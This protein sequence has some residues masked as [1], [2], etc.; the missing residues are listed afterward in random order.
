MIPVSKIGWSSYSKFE[1]PFF[2]GTIKV[3][4]VGPDATFAQKVL[5]LTAAAEGGSWNAVNMYDSG[6]VSLGAIQF[7]DA[8]SFNVCNML[9]YIAEKCG[10]EP[11]VSKLKPALDLCKATFAKTQNGS[12]RFHVD[13]R[14][15]S[16]LD[17]QKRLY[18]G[19]SDGNLKGTFDANKKIIAKTWAAC[20]ASV[21]EIDGAVQAQLEFTMPR[22]INGFVWGKLKEDLYG[23]DAPNDGY[24]GM[25]RGMLLS[26]A[27]N[28]PALVVKRYNDARANPYTIY[29]DAWCLHILR[30]VV[31]GS[32]IKV[33]P[34]RWSTKRDLVKSMW[35]IQLPTWSEISSEMWKPTAESSV[36]TTHV[37][38]TLPAKQDAI[39]LQEPVVEQILVAQNDNMPI[40]HRTV[41]DETKRSLE[42]KRDK[43]NF[44]VRQ[45]S[46][47][48][49][50]YG[51]VKMMLEIVLRVLG[52]NT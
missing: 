8:G 10:V 21:M 44:V 22:L 34:A 31:V 48:H 3:P 32:N 14:P 29:T 5:S 28:A 9:G 20:V 42:T 18:F 25:L 43:P 45:A 11:V 7:I 15:I 52:K 27:V 23:N 1:G 36:A 38:E 39:P 41:A 13:G 26:F 17:D 50:V 30:S 33:W 19:D 37:A 16:T 6:L 47:L 4:K 12:W 35:G 24:V 49:I 2:G 40:E 51:F 46:F